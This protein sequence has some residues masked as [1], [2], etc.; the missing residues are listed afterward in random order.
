MDGIITIDEHGTVESFNAAA[1]QLFGYTAAE[2]IGHNV[3]LLMPAPYRE[4]H[5]GYLARYLHTGEKKIIGIGR[6]V[7]GQRKDGTT[8][9][10]ALAVSEMRLG[11]RRM[12]TGIVHDITARKQAE[13]A[14]G[15]PATTSNG[16]SRNARPSWKWRTRRCDASPTLCPTTCGH[17]W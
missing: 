7:V 2:V 10:L 5:D 1:E 3:R 16:A 14:R 12:F 11:T 8:F 6:E 17:R 4:E 9:P 15:R 13:D